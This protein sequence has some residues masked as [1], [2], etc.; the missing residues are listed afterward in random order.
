MDNAA[1][2]AQQ[3]TGSVASPHDAGWDAARAAWNLAVDQQ[4]ALVVFAE[5]AAD[6]AAAMTFA[7]AEGLKVAP[8]GTG[9]GA[10]S[11]PAL[12]HTALLR[13]DR[14]TGLHIDPE[15][16]T[17][18]VE[19][20][21]LWRD[22]VAGATPHGL[23]GLHGSSGGVG[24][25]GY[26]LGGGI[27]WLARQYGLACSHVTAM[28]VVTAD[29]SERRI[30]DANDAELFWALCGGGGAYA[31]VTALEFALV[32]LERVY[33]GSLMW[34]LD[35]APEVL[36][37]YRDWAAGAPETIT[38]AL[39]LMRFPPLPFLPDMLRGQ[40]LVNI[41][42]AATDP[43]AEAE[44]LV[45]P[46]RALGGGYLDSLA[47]V[48]AAALAEIAG[49][50]P[51]PVPAIAGGH[52]LLERLDDDAI[53]TVL[54]LA[55]PGVDLPLLSFELRQGGGALHRPGPGAGATIGGELL[56]SSVGIVP[57]PEAAAAIRSVQEQIVERLQPFATGLTYLNFAEERPGTRRSMPGEVAD[58]LQ[59]VKATYDPDGVIVSAHAV[60]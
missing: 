29:G 40:S 48:P 58:R 55:G 23:T 33:A 25:V 4:P 57:S 36:T 34:Q 15:A 22:V 11:L 39:S 28:D 32:P 51:D 44:E 31:V 13:T 16:R 27:G 56:T 52:V 3:L 37:A 9:H 60:D 45:A 49:D 54:G 18:R 24:V 30:D 41:T 46:L 14:L 42:L 10:L 59:Q 35:R 20:G 7:R 21:V 19:A 2:L 38:S 26:T 8:Q 50:P 53:A 43:T 17:A 1:A 47:E 5:T 6:V 12:D